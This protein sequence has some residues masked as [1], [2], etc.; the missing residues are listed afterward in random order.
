MAATVSP[1]T[2]TPHRGRPGR[3]NPRLR[4]KYAASPATNTGSWFARKRGLWRPGLPLCGVMVVGLTAAAIALAQARLPY[5]YVLIPSLAGLS[6]VF[7]LELFAQV[8]RLAPAW[9]QWIG[10]IS[11]SMYIF[12]FTVV[13]LLCRHVFGAVMLDWPLPRL[14]LALGV[15][16]GITAVIAAAS[17]R[18]IER[19]GI[20]LGRRLIRRLA[21]G[22]KVP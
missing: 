5:S 6:F 11:Y 22:G 16:V 9:L 3:H 20:A 18:W 2:I 15:T 14:A 17:E 19:P 12:H 8:P 7:L 13:Y 1:T 21:A 4:A 10:R